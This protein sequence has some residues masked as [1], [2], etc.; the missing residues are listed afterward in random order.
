MKWRTDPIRRTCMTLIA[1]CTV[2]HCLIANTARGE[3]RQ[4][5][6]NAGSSLRIGEKISLPTLSLDSAMA[7]TDQYFFHQ[8][9]IQQ[10]VDSQECRLLDEDGKLHAQGSYAE[11]RAKIDAIRREQHMEPMHGKA[12]V[13]LHGLAAPCWS[14]Q[15]LARHLQK[16]GGYEVFPVDYASTRSTIDV[17]AQSL[18]RVIESL[19]G[20]E[21]INLVGHSMGNIVIRRY[22]A[23]DAS[24]TAGW[25]PDRRIARIVMIAPPNHGSITATRLSDNAVFKAA[26]GESARQLGTEWKDLETRLATPNC[27][28]GIIAGGCGNRLGLNPFLAGDDDGRITVETTRLAG[29][30]DFLVIPA[31]HEFIAND[32]RVFNYTLHFL[33]EGCFVA[34]DQRHAIPRTEIAA[35]PGSVRK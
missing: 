18:A 7:W 23:G 19:E 29:A 9:R 24:P 12:V 17:Q 33:T 21:E 22:L 11:C 25:Q 26:L 13:L 8:W 20:I 3:D 32:P 27:E 5:E 30:S 10:H 35:Q 31:V 6:T 15:M 2:L 28:F 14:M 1:V 34:P 16:H 4:G